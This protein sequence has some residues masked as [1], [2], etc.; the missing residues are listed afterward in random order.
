MM[1]LKKKKSHIKKGWIAIKG[2]GELDTKIAN[3]LNLIVSKNFQVKWGKTFE[4]DGI[5][6]LAL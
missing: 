5:V 2:I 6:V 4:N 1:N 3:K